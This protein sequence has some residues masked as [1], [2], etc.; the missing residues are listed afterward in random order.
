[1]ENNIFC[2]LAAIIKAEVCADLS[3]PISLLYCVV[4]NGKSLLGNFAWLLYRDKVYQ[5]TAYFAEYASPNLC[6]EEKAYYVC[7]GGAL[8]CKRSTEK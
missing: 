2:T 4:T 3:N 8:P 7:L 1:M 6:G 5:L